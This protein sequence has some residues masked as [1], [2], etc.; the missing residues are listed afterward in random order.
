MSRWKTLSAVTFALFCLAPQDSKAPKLDPK[1]VDE[2]IDKG[3]A[4]LL[5]E[6][7]DGIGN[8]SWTSPVELVVLTLNH[9]NVKADNPVY[10]TCLEKMMEAKLQYT[11]RVSLMAMA[12][13]RIDPKKYQDRIAE[14]AQWLVDTQCI[15][16]EW[17]YP[18]T[19][20]DEKSHPKAVTV[21]PPR[22][23]TPKGAPAGTEPKWNIRR[24]VRPDP[25]I[26]GDQSNAQFALLGLR[27]CQE[28]GIDIPK[29]TWAM[30][31]KFML[32][33]QRPDGGWGYYFKDMRDRASY[34]SLT[35][36]GIAA[37]AICRY[38]LGTKDPLRDPS[39]QRGLAWMSRRLD[40]AENPG[41]T[42]S[43]VIDPLAWHYYYLYSIE[44]TGIILNTEKFGAKEWYPGGAQW[45]I[46]NQHTDG[47]WHTG[48]SLQW[49]AAGSMLVPDTCLAL[50]FLTRSTPPLVETGGKKKPP[51]EPPKPE[52][53]KPK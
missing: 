13:H 16:G 31:L 43:N 21:E 47:S 23:E 35:L 10:K 44:R 48:I 30:A 18:G 38:Y 45:L 11:Y 46:R 17:G 40:F 6:Y 26:K 32:Y 33:T 51:E 8:S 49:T 19:L 5:K 24:R 2:A 12:L 29:E 27:A 36:A 7:K 41:V 15:E 14:C 34:G 50:L 25:K 28:S 22:K 39:V 53:E 4:F 9:A 42:G 1:K 37:V 52:D 20:T 3:A